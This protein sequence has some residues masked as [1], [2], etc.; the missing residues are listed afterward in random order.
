MRKCSSTR[1]PLRVPGMKPGE[2][3]YIC[4]SKTHIA[5]VCCNTRLLLSRDRPDDFS[6]KQF[7][8]YVACTN[9]PSCCG[10]SEMLDLGCFRLDR[11]PSTSQEGLLESHIVWNDG[12]NSH[13]KARG[14]KFASCFICKEHGNISKNCP[15]NK[16]GVYPMG[17]CCKVCGSV[18]HLVKDCPDKLNRDSAPT[19]SSSNI[20]CF[21]RLKRR[22]R[23]YT[24]RQ[25]HQ[26][27]YGDDL[28]DDFYEEPKSSKKNKTFDDVITPDNVDEKR[29][30]K[31]KQG[32]TIVNFFG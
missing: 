28:E 4:K 7:P 17:G 20:F 12:P 9:G 3:C 16:H 24:T 5:K 23:C 14:T 30:L 32:P 13:P 25:T 26:V 10:M 31:K 18:A 21:K 15:Q 22:I 1:H 19:K 11:F 29:I 2:G 6:Y 27:Q 8:T